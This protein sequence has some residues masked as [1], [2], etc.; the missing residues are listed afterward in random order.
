MK[1][2]TRK[3]IGTL[4]LVPYVSIYALGAMLGAMAI[5]PGA[6]AFGQAIYYAVAG[7]A[8]IVPAAFLIKW[9]A[10]PDAA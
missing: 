3:L 8:W 10:K 1:Q 7:L 4:V 6:P 5:L 9:M 2:R